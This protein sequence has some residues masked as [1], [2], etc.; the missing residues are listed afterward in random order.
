MR[1]F[2][3]AAAGAGRLFCAF[4]GG[5]E[6]KFCASRGALAAIFARQDENKQIPPIREEFRFH[7]IA[8]IR[9]ARRVLRVK[10]MQNF[11]KKYL[12]SNPKST[13]CMTLLKTCACSS[14]G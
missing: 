14:I 6:Q 4:M 9:R 10:K 12:Q 8:K 1:V 11:E 2:F 3:F 7:C 5:A 13:S